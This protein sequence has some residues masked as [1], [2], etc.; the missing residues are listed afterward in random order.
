MQLILAYGYDTS[1]LRIGSE[2]NRNAQCEGA[3]MSCLCIP[4]GFEPV[5]RLADTREFESLQGRGRVGTS[6]GMSVSSSPKC[7]YSPLV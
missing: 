4:S 5:E 6:Y 3:K 7:A 1:Q 2:T